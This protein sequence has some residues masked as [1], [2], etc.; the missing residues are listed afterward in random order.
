MSNSRGGEEG[1]GAPFLPSSPLFPRQEPQEYT[2]TPE[3]QI[4]DSQIDAEMQDSPHQA[5]PIL[6]SIQKPRKNLFE[7]SDPLNHSQEGQAGLANSIHRPPGPL[8]SQAPRKRPRT[9]NPSSFFAI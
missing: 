6:Q 7:S 4:T 3:D 1:Y 8:I 2:P 9:T 5:V